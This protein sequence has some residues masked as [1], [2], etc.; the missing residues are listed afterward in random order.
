MKLECSNN[1]PEIGRKELTTPKNSAVLED[2]PT[3]TDKDMVD[4][5]RYPPVIA[6]P[7]LAVHYWSLIPETRNSQPSRSCKIQKERAAVIKPW[8]PTHIS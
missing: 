6:I 5:L 3:S 8:G 7:S 4:L 1:K 2:A